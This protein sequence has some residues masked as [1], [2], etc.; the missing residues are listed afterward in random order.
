MIEALI[1]RRDSNG[2][3]HDFQGP[4]FVESDRMMLGLATR[5][6]Q[7]DPAKVGADALEGES[8]AARWDR[9]VA[10]VCTYVVSSITPQRIF[11]SIVGP[12]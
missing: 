9:C 1:V 8:T 12:Y 11:Y 7:L 2:V 4:Y 6:L 10:K 5:Y 3:I